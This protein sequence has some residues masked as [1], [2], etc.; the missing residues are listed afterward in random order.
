M[1]KKKY[2]IRVNGILRQMA[3][4][5]SRVLLDILRRESREWTD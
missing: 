5:P 4:E 3:A 1:I 2:Q